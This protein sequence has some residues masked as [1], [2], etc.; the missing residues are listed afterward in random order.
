MQKLTL[1]FK[2]IFISHELIAIVITIL[3]HIV[4]IHLSDNNFRK[5]KILIMKTILLAA[6]LLFFIFDLNA[7]IVYVEPVQNAKYV[8]INNN[9]IIGFDEMIES[10]NLNSLI[11][12]RGT[13]SGI[14]PGEIIFTAD[15]KKLIFKPYQPF[16]FNEKVEVK[17]NHLKTSFTSNN[18]LRCTFQTQVSK[19]DWDYS[20]SMI[21]EYGFSL[22][23]NFVYSD[24][25]GVLPQL[26]VTIS[27]NPSPGHLF[28]ANLPSANYN[29]NIIIANNDGTMN[30][31]REIAPFVADFSR[32]PNGLLAYY[33]T[34]YYAED[35]QYNVVDSFY[36]GNGYS[37]DAHELRLLNNGHALLMS[38]DP[39]LVDMSVIVPGGNPNASVIGLII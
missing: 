2:F 5:L 30:Y 31:T 6:A 25:Y 32:Q 8:S 34:K 20:K 28:L 7:K 39:Q 13:I 14:H 33:N 24:N 10:S 18:R 37:T 12:V 26:T 27:N 4:L 22:N 15:K 1:I 19:P 36:C 21:E 9:I 3:T 29:T 11:S 16:A 23:N 35:S 38:Y 17:L